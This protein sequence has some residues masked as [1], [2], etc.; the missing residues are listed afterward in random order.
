MWEHPIL[1]NIHFIINHL[2][3]DHRNIMKENDMFIGPP[4]L[5]CKH[6]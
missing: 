4:L 5:F 6:G 1:S 3:K 2:M